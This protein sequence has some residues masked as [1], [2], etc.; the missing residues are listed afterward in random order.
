MKEEE[1]PGF[2]M[3][4]DLS[5]RNNLGGGGSGGGGG[6]AQPQPAGF[7]GYPLAPNLPSM[8]MPPSNQPFSY[9]SGG[10]SGG[11]G[12]LSGPSAPFNYNIP[13]N[14]QSTAPSQ[15]EKKDLNT[16]FLKVIYFNSGAFYFQLKMSII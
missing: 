13:P 4:I 2:G 15:P 5:D 12:S 3:L 11:T 9:P 6:S 16:E 1:P 10:G 14:P 7:I 8:P